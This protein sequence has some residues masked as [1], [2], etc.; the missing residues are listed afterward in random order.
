MGVVLHTH[1]CDDEDLPWELKLILMIFIMP[2]M[3]AHVRILVIA[4][5]SLGAMFGTRDSRALN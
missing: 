4:G 1:S 2:L 5:V 3:C